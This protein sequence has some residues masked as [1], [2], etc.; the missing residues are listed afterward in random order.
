M[1]GA[2]LRG[3]DGY[4]QG[5]SLDTRDLQAGELFVAVLG[6]R[7]DGHDYIEQAAARGASAALVSRHVPASIPTLQ[8]A[9][10]V[11]ALA[12]LA[13]AWRMRH[14]VKVVALTG[15]NGKTT[16]KNMLAGIFPADQTLVTAGN[17]NNELGLPLTL[18][19]LTET[20][21]QAVLEMGA[22][23]P[24]DIA[25]LA[26][27]A[28]PNVAMVTNA[29][30]AHLD[31]FG[32]VGAVAQEK[33]QIYTQLLDEGI[34]VV[35]FDD[36][37]A[38]LWAGL[39]GERSCLG[40]SLHPS[41]DPR[42]SVFARQADPLSGELLIQVADQQCQTRLPIGGWHNIAN[43]VAAAAMAHAAGVEVEQIG[44]GLAAFQPEAG[45]LQLKHLDGA[46]LIDDSYNAN[47]ASVKAAIDFLSLSPAGARWLVLGQMCALGEDSAE[48]HVEIGRYAQDRGIER[49]WTLGADSSAA[50]QGFHGD[51]RCFDDHDALSHALRADWR[52]DLCCLVKGSRAMQME[53]VVD[54]LMS[55]RCDAEGNA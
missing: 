55:D 47:P 5:A 39:I 37:Y 51:F 9:D 7:V 31:R 20:H 18:L 42:V 29:G 54:A 8:V 17:R 38:G 30:P 46:Q 11:S 19:G 2:E 48:R 22:G 33:G 44:A 1:L 14:G 50:A 52:A 43:A 27:I 34:G 4:F 28:R 40:C 16:T 10:V 32:T 49:L 36:H 12:E 13:S 53:R 25:E 24:G 3:G 23:G 15:S 35:N 6:E 45:R 21:R 26:G 41:T